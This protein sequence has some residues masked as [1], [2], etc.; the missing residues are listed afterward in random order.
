MKLDDVKS[1]AREKGIKVGKLN[2]ADLIRAIQTQENNTPCFSTGLE[3]C[4][5]YQCLW[6]ADCFPE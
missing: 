2:K 3:S 4:D 1:L 6:R 5:Q